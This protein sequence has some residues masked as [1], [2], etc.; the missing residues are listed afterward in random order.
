MIQIP[1]SARPFFQEYTF[2]NLDPVQH[3]DLV[4]E[5]LLAYGDREEIRW[6]YQ[7]YGRDQIS[8]W[9]GINGARL[10]PRLRYNLWCII[11]QLQPDEEASKRKI[12]PH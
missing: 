3:R 12:W 4:I 10:L 5:R 1:T 9:V 6:L 8:S 11:F 2:E 7:T